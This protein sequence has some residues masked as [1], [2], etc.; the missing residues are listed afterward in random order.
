MKRICKHYLSMD[1]NCITIV[2]P[3]AFMEGKKKRERN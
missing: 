1:E 3:D 2:C